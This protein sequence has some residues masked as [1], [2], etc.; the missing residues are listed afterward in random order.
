MHDLLIRTIFDDL[1]TK[2][3]HLLQFFLSHLILSLLSVFLSVCVLY[4]YG[5]LSGE[6]I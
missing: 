6:K 3:I 2:V 5:F 1:K 4:G